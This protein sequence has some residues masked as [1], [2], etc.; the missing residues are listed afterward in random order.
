MNTIKLVCLISL[1]AFA[2]SQ[3]S[4]YDQPPPTDWGL[5]PSLNDDTL[6]T[7]NS[8][9]HH[10]DSSP[11]DIV[12]CRFQND[13]IFVLTETNNLYRSMGQEFNDHIS[14]ENLQ[15]LS[16]QQLDGSQPQPQVI[17]K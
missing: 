10:V 16:N 14:T 11:I 12:W 17:Y 5:T 3:D 8:R 9:L 1:F 4:F 15:Q 7:V 13:V 2:C 6:N